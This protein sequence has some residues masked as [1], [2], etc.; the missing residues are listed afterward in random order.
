MSTLII[1]IDNNNN[2]ET[3]TMMNGWIGDEVENMTHF[4]MDP[5]STVQIYANEMQIS[6]LN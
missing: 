3:N 5:W 4:I 2:N 1:W 6:N